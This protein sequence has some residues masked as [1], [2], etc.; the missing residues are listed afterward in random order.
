MYLP[1]TV[2][3]NTNWTEEY[4]ACVKPFILLNKN[5]SVNFLVLKY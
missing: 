4:F 3:V 2:F 5:G 1:C